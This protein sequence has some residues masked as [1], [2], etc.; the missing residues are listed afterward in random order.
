MSDWCVGVCFNLSSRLTNN[1]FVKNYHR[2]WNM[3][4]LLCSWKQMTNLQCKQLTSPWHMSTNEDTAHHFF[5]IKGTVLFEFIL[6]GQ[7]VNW[8]YFVEILLHLHEAVHRKRPKLWP[9][10]W[11][12]HHNYDS[13]HKVL[14]SSSWPRSWSWK[15]N[16]HPIPLIWLWMISG[17]FQK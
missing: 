4:L 2:G 12:L 3:V 10:D 11:I 1:F 9:N 6:Q 14:S 5:D 8:A 17:Y 15:W 16:T 13:A 7:T